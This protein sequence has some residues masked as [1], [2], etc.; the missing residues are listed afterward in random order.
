[1]DQMKIDSPWKLTTV[2]GSGPFP[3]QEIDVSGI[4]RKWLDVAYADQSPAQK[5]DIFLPDEGEGPFPVYIF[6]HGGAYLFGAKRDAQLFHAI[7]GVTKGYAVVSVEQRLAG[8]AQFPYGLFDLKAAIRY[9]RANAAQYKLDPEKFALAGDS[10]GAYYAIMCAATQDIPGFEDETM[11]NAGVSSKVQAVIGFYGCYDLMKMLPP[12]MPEPPKGAAP[13]PGAGGPPMPDLYQSLVGAKPRAIYGLMYFTNPFNFITENFPP[14]LIQAGTKDQIVPPSQSQML[15]DKVVE[16][17]G[18]GRAELEF[19]EGWNHG[20]F[21]TDWYEPK[22][23]GH[24]YQFLD[25]LFK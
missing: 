6:M 18:E 2:Q 20:G 14:I 1:M 10:A 7:D 15:Y 11:G 13:G 16:K 3:T 4:K 12:E 22:H 9:L 8:E 19:F 24:I 25:K 5:L 17:C 21:S 23:Q